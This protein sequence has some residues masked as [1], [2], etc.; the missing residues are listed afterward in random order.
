MLE[1]FARQHRQL[2]LA[3]GAELKGG[4]TFEILG[5]IKQDSLLALR[6]KTACRTL[7]AGAGFEPEILGYEPIRT[8]HAPQRDTMSP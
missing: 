8:V 3:A 5:R 2:M 7:V 4:H 6:Q 1:V